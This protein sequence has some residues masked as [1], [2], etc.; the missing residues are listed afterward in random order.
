[1]NADAYTETTSQM[2]GV[3]ASKS[4]LR[5]LLLHRKRQKTELQRLREKYVSRSWAST[6]QKLDAFIMELF[7]GALDGKRG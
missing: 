5:Q 7:T 2:P 3:Y 1:M 4:E 6:N